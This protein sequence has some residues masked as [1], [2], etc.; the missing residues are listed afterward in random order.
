MINN[1]GDIPDVTPEI[2]EISYGVR[3]GSPARVQVLL[4]KAEVMRWR[5]GSGAGPLPS[6]G[7]PSRS[8]PCTRGIEA[9]PARW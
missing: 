7:R 4:D 9:T 2:A 8:S 6:I 5:T 1:G 3:E